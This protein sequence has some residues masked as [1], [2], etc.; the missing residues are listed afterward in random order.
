MLHKRWKNTLIVKLW[1]RNIG[2]KALCNKNLWKLKESV[3]VVDLEHNFYF[4]RFFNR[5]D[6]LHALTDGPWIVFGHCLIVEPWVPQFN[7]SQHKI[8]TV[9]AWVQIP[10]LSCEYYDRRLLHI[11][12]NMIGHLVRIDHN[13]AEAIRHIL[14][15]C[16]AQTPMT[17]VD[18]VLATASPS[19]AALPAPTTVDGGPQVQPRGEWMIVAPRQ[20]QQPRSASAPANKESIPGKE[21]SSSKGVI[22]GK[23]IGSHFDVLTDYVTVERPSPIIKVPISAPVLASREVN[24]NDTA[25]LGPIPG[26]VTPFSSPQ[27]VL[28]QTSSFAPT[29]ATPQINNN[30]GAIMSHHVGLVT[31]NSN[32]LSMETPSRPSSSNLSSTSDNNYHDP[33]PQTSSL[34]LSPHLQRWT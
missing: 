30:E 34:L 7:P 27:S 18:G 17:M 25:I 3:R 23:N 1:G 15:S 6:Y 16:P 32:A 28:I 19:T 22:Q 12:C 29:M 26:L 5:Q 11:V 13:T 33:A 10:E 31:A 20:R 4:V 14:A 8:K 9:V 21:N 2:F 24:S